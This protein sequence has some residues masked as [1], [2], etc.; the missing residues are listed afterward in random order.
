MSGLAYDFSRLATRRRS[1]D[2]AAQGITEKD[3]QRLLA[4]GEIE[5]IGRGRY[6]AREAEVTEHQTLLQAA[7]LVPNGVVCLLSALRFHDLTTQAP[8][9]V[10][11]VV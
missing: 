7:L 6:R 8:F 9:V 1:R 3:L 5:R 4:S 10:A 11:P 2:L